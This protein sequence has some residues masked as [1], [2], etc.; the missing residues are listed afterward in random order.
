MMPFIHTGL[1]TT[2]NLICYWK[3]T[4]WV[5]VLLVQQQEHQRCS[6]ANNILELY[7]SVNE[8]VCAWGREHRKSQLKVAY[9]SVEGYYI[10]ER[11]HQFTLI[12]H[13]CS[14][15]WPFGGPSFPSSHLTGLAL[16]RHKI[17]TF[18]K[19][20]CKITYASKAFLKGRVGSKKWH[21]K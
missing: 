5:G 8:Q 11:L 16:R 1:D 9:G 2:D 18:K 6:S 4:T 10:L 15:A 3:L 20:I 13:K 21:D 14:W 17:R 7:V 19:I 12:C